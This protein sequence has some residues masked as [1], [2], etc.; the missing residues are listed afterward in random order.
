MFTAI[1]R[2]LRVIRYGHCERLAAARRARLGGRPVIAVTGSAAKTTTV[3]LLGHLLGGPPAVGISMYAN[4]ARNVLGQFARM[5]PGTTCA[6][7]EASEFPPGNLARA[8]TTIQPTAAVLT[9]SGFDH[10]TAFRGV[11]AVA[12]EMATLAHM[13]PADGMVVVN[14]D[15]DDLRRVIGDVRG[16]LVMFG[17]HPDADYRAVDITIGPQHTV[18]ITCRH[19]GEEVVL[20][21]PFVGRQFHVP[22]LAAVAAAHGLGMAWPE[23]QD[24]LAGFEPVFGRCSLVTVPDGPMFICD[25]TKAPVWSMASSVETLDAFAS[26]PRR[27]LV[28]GTLSDYP[29][30]SRRAYRN[31]WRHARERVDRAI[32]LR[33]TPSHVGAS[34]DEIAAGRTLFMDSVQAIAAHVRE[35]AI[36]GEVILLKG[37]SLAD[38]LDRIAHDATAPVACWIDKC[39]LN[40]NCIN[41]EWMQDRTPI[42]LRP[43]KSLRHKL[44]GRQR[45]A[46]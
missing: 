24:R 2:Q 21:T 46:G 22:T 10:Y 30:D 12:A 40:R 9:I 6:V 43:L 5:G 36:S 35:T 33:H 14:A 28:L 18:T 41:C 23:I 15:D 44:A 7:V 25:T 29:G 32:F 17:L 20:E 13:V 26:A 1:R 38:H 39:G 3:K 8:A 34:A 16:R 27:T 11:E 31:V 45:I 37:S 19:G 4:T 42:R